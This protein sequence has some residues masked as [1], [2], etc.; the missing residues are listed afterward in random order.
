MAIPIT[1]NLRNLIVRKTTTL[2]TAL[3]IALTV[4]VLLAMMA[5]VHGLAD[6][7]K[8]TGNPLQVLVMRKGATSELVSSVTPEQFQALK[9]KPG[10]ARDAK[11]SPMAS[12]EI[13]TVIN[14]ESVDAPD[15]NNV[16]VRGVSPE[17]LA[18]REGLQ[19]VKGRWFTPGRR[20]VVAGSGIAKRFPG[21]KLGGKLHFGRGDWDVVGVM[22]A[23]ESA[24]ASE[25]FGDLNQVSS[26]FQRSDALSSVLLRATDPVAA[27]ALA[28][29]IEAD[30]RIGLKALPETEY[31][32]SLTS[33]GAPIQFLGTFVAL[34]M[35]V[36]SSFAAMNTMYAAVARRSRE[37]GTLRVLGFSKSTIL[38]SFFVESV[39]LA[40]LGG[41]LGVLL[42]LPLNGLTTGVGNFTTFS[43][44]A[45][46]LK[47][48]L[49]IICAGIAFAVVLGGLGGLFPAQSAARKEILVALRQV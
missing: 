5:L 36:G 29:S 11:G 43:E 46:Q 31:Y 41:V 1:Y 39:L 25:V 6:S 24:V 23:G 19:L 2:M 28:R 44:S 12:L 22:Q 16:T 49:P 26:D 7:L 20:E 14:L 47:V 3:G 27:D 45:F 37:I 13:V 8:A 40:A 15:G 18:M 32:A 42:V 33:S 21:A 4:A 10:V 30:Q 38:F 34:I 9:F 48:T 17:G 35:A